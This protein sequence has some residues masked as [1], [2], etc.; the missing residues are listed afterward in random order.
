MYRSCALDTSCVSYRVQ[1]VSFLLFEGLSGIE[2][3]NK[4]KLPHSRRIHLRCKTTAQ[5]L[6]ESHITHIDYLS[7]DVEGHEPHILR[8]IDWKTTSINIISIEVEANVA[9]AVKILHEN[10]FKRLDT[11]RFS[12]SVP[13]LAPNID[14][15]YL[16]ERVV[17]GHPV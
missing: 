16:H 8:G 12:K 15:I 10:G 2:E 11:S 14:A 6:S 13:E 1:N 5:A 4:N 7:L 9:E 17:W 3:T